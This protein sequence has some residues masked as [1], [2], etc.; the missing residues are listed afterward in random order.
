MEFEIFRKWFYI[1]YPNAYRILIS[2]LKNFVEQLTR[3]SWSEL[4]ASIGYSVSKLFNKLNELRVSLTPSNM[5]LW[6]FCIAFLS[7]FRAV[8]ASSPVNIPESIFRILFWAKSRNARPFKFLKDTPGI[9]LRWQP[10]KFRFLR[11]DSKPRR[12]LLDKEILL[13]PPNLRVRRR[14]VTN[15]LS[16]TNFILLLVRSSCLSNLNFRN[17]WTGTDRSSLSAKFRLYK[18]KF[19]VFRV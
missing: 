13:F 9:S 3:S 8:S 19:E 11:D 1:C 6:S 2:R 17:A 4:I 5:S 7:R 12:A 18:K 14:K 15:A 16:G 10:F